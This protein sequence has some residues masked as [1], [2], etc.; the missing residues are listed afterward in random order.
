MWSRLLIFAK[1]LHGKSIAEMKVVRNTL[2][3]LA[4][5]DHPESDA[6]LQGEFV[7]TNAFV[8]AYED[9]SVLLPKPWLSS[10]KRLKLLS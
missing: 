5:K 4:L 9:P 1:A 10:A 3:Q 8:F 7:G 6:A 2:A